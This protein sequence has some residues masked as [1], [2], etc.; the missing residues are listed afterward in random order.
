MIDRHRYRAV[1]VDF[2]GT[3]TTGGRPR[4]EVLAAMARF[5]RHGRRIVMVTGR[6]MEE[7]L[8][9]FADVEDHVDG[10]VAENGGVF[11][12]AGQSQLLARSVEPALLARLSSG[13]VAARAGEVLVATGAAHLDY[14]SHCVAELGL[15]CQLIM[16]RSELMVLPS[17]VSKGTGLRAGLAE[18]GISR[19]NAIAIGDAE[20]D[21]SLLHSC[22]VGVAVANAVPAL[23]AAADVVTI[24]QDGDGVIEVLN[25]FNDADSPPLALPTVPQRWHITLG[26]DPAD[27]TPVRLA[28]AHE[29]LLIVGPSHSGKSY[30]AGLIAEQLV[31]LGYRIFAF[32]PEGDHAQLCTLPGVIAVGGTEPLVPPSHLLSLIGHRMGGVVIDL[33]LRP[34]GE[35]V[36]FLQRIPAVIE[37]HRHATGLP[38]WV[39]VDEAHQLFERTHHTHNDA[40]TRSA[41]RYAHPGYCLV[42]YRP[43]EVPIDVLDSIGIVLTLPGTAGDADWLNRFRPDIDTFRPVIEALPPDQLLAIR[44]THQPQTVRLIGRETSHVRH[45]RKYLDGE[46]DHEYR[47]VFRDLEDRVVGSA[48]SVAAL[49]NQLTHC[50]PGV[51]RHHCAGCDFSSWIHDVFADTDFA[52]D[53]RKVETSS[54]ARAQ[55]SPAAVERARQELLATIEARYLAPL[56][57]AP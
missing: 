15:E 7:L 33:S 32:D 56:A 14:V 11:Y 8:G 4:P 45:H 43:D 1:A 51:I 48:A 22:E 37:A 53:I 21:H 30:V 55:D 42:T 36:E 23:L 28:A 13:D 31:R 3:L 49:H 10:I 5:R 40:P 27:G 16:N 24:G 17:G 47:F 12:R 39:L 9:V 18:F 6:I 44:R 25:P 26:T 2:D 57:H 20:N 46:L 35:A 41:F 50:E 19:H 29:N 54:D 38:H 34:R 52:A